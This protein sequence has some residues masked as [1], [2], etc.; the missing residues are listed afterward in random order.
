MTAAP[1]KNKTNKNTLYNIKSSFKLR[2]FLLHLITYEKNDWDTNDDST[3]QNQG[4]RL[5]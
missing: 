1:D 4:A 3:S 2:R 5:I